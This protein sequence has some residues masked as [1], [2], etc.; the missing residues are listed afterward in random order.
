MGRIE[1]GKK[2][3]RGF[4]YYPMGSYKSSFFNVKKKKLKS[5]FFSL[6]F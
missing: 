3:Q 1:S 5:I 6:S 4:G 2:G